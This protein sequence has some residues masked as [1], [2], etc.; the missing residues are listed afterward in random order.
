MALFRRLSFIMIFIGLIGCGGGDGGLDGGST[1]DV[2]NTT[3]TIV[4]S[5]SIS[6]ELVTEQSPATITATVMQGTDP[7]ASTVVTFE[8]TLGAFSSGVRNCINRCKWR[9]YHSTYRR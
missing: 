3:D 7:I 4:V 6:D 1:P 8:T 2:D 9:C 5:L